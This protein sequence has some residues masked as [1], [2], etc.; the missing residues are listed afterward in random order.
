MWLRFIEQAR[1]GSFLGALNLSRAKGGLLPYNIYGEL[2]KCFSIQSSRP[3]W[4]KS[5]FLFLEIRSDY[6]TYF[7]THLLHR[8]DGPAGQG[9][10]MPKNALS[11]DDVASAVL[12][13]VNQVRVPMNGCPCTLSKGGFT[14]GSKI[15][16]ALKPSNC[17]GWEQNFGPKEFTP[18]SRSKV[19]DR[20]GC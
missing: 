20:E 13:I 11:P 9:N 17:I 12:T 4:S 7:I 16:E 8:W 2:D 19:W 10:T 6:V 1:V 18:R 14:L 5:L 15:K 3:V